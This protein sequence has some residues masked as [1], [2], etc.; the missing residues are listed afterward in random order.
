MKKVNVSEL[1]SKL[2]AYLRAVRAGHEVI[3]LDRNL[4]VARITAIPEAEILTYTAASA[5]VVD[6][7]SHLPAL[8]GNKR[9]LNSLALLI[10][11]RERR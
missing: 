1:K 11:D 2:S 7:F 5:S 4:P 9:T 6:V 10:A 3:V 8:S